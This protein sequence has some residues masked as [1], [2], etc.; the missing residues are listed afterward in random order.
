MTFPKRARR[1]FTMIELLVV[2]GIIVLLLA[3]LLPVV[4]QVRIRAFVA[5]TEAEMAK[6]Q[7]GCLAYYHDFNSYPGPLADYQLIGGPPPP[8]GAGPL[9]AN[10]TSNP[11]S[12][13]NLTLGLLGFLGVRMN[14]TT[15]FPVFQGTPQPSGGTGSTTPFTPGD[16]VNL[17]TR[18][19][20][21]HYIDY[22]P[23]EVSQTGF[24]FGAMGGQRA[25]DTDPTSTTVNKPSPETISDTNVPEFLDR[26][27]DAMPILYMRAHVGVKTS[28]PNVGVM[29][30]NSPTTPA[31]YNRSQLAP[32]GFNNVSAIDF[33]LPSGLSPAPTG[34]T[35]QWMA[36]FMNP[37]I[38]YQARGADG[39]ILISAGADR[40]YGTKDD[41]IV[42]P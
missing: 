15:P 23:T 35:P 10:I 29:V 42:T 12:S 11:T 8:Q 3:I 19:G 14:G 1:G 31:Q 16:V 18:P 2:I 7:A 36:Y 13:E 38:A 25:T 21:F 24:A 22:D 6:I 33:N 20:S 9:P 34:D 32:Y 30:T 37:A 17:G 4:S 5:S 40:M 27:P 39:F 28:P 41:I 26:I